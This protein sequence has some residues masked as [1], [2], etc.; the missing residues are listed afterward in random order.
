MTN[1]ATRLKQEQIIK[2][3]KVELKHAGQSHLYV[4]LKKAYGNPSLRKHITQ[5]LHKKI[6]LNVT[7]LAASG[8]GG[9]PLATTL[10][11]QHD[12]NLTLIREER[13]GY[14]T[15]KHIDGYQPQ[16][17]DVIAVVD[18]VVTTGNSLKKIV[19]KLEHTKGKV[20]G[21][22]VVVD[23]SDQKLPVQVESLLTL[24][25]LTE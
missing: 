1:L 12:Y 16:N 8:H 21:C 13:K 7:T 11:D 15:E 17:H 20:Q 4:D 18:D 2:E 10:S 22:Y 14:G 9:I 3:R 25:D 24:E 5:E 19:D 23:R 6:P